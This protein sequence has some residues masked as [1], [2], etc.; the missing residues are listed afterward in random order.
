MLVIEGA[1]GKSIILAEKMKEWNKEQTIIVDNVDIKFLPEGCLVYK[2]EYDTT[3]EI[4]EQI[5]KNENEFK[6]FKRIVFL[7]NCP[8]EDMLSIW[9]L[10]QQLMEKYSFRECVAT[11]QNNSLEEVMIYEV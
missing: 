6:S 11:I 4:I 1:N 10:E 7:I 5:G 3:K 8:K 2:S 9:K